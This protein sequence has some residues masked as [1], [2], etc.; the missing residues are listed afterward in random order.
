MT[1]RVPDGRAATVAW[2][3]LNTDV[4]IPAIRLAHPTVLIDE[5]DSPGSKSRRMDKSF[6][7]GQP[8][9][10]CAPEGMPMG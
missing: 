7:R 10:G 8:S 1:I 3:A 6:C 2:P 4:P 5:L 9:Q